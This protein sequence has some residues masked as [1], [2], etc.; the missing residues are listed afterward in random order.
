MKILKT[1]GKVVKPLVNVPAWMGLNNLV[2]SFVGIVH[3]IRDFFVPAKKVEASKEPFEDILKRLNLTEETVT[4]RI[5]QFKFIFRILV[6]IGL[7]VLSYAIY[8]LIHGHLRAFF[9]SLA[10]LG[11]DIAQ[12]FY[13]HF[14]IFQMQQRKLGCT[15]HEWLGQFK[16]RGIP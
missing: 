7:L 6:L 1:A 2:A 12:A 9:V 4:L 13:Y 15:F 16:S 11:I 8:L 3:L 10:I 5:K 14:W